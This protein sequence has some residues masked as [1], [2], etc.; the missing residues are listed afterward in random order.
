[1]LN[2]H[3]VP[4]IV[5][6]MSHFI[7]P[8]LGQ[9]NLPLYLTE[10]EAESHENEQLAHVMWSSG[11][12]FLTSRPGTQS[13][14]PLLLTTQGR[15]SVCAL[16]LPRAWSTGLSGSWPQCCLVLRVWDQAW[17]P[18]DV[19]QLPTKVTGHYAI[20]DFI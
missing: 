4:D 17:W 20:S 2:T 14:S 19:G 6:T 12:L 15:L 8:R 11:T 10:M 3:L 16:L 13:V 5:H 18:A 1:M 7:P 9:V